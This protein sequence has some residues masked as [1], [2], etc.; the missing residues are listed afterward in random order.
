MDHDWL[1]GHADALSPAE[2]RLIAQAATAREAIGEDDLE[3]Y[4]QRAVPPA[5]RSC[6]FCGD[7][8][9]PRDDRKTPN[10]TCARHCPDGGA[11]GQHLPDMEYAEIDHGRVLVPCGTCGQVGTLSGNV[12]WSLE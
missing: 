1:K 6:R 8:V 2:R 12:D 11:D 9:V 7:A 3:R 4:A 5:T 10:I